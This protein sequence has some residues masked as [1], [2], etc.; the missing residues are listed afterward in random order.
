MWQI[1][2]V[3]IGNQSAGVIKSTASMLLRITNDGDIIQVD[4]KHYHY[5]YTYR[6]FRTISHTGV[7]TVEVT[8]GD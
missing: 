6:K 3:A 5:Y 2:Y 8:N 7:L 1:F 4:I